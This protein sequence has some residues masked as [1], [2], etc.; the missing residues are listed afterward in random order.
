M[1]I[2]SFNVISL[3]GATTVLATAAFA[4]EMTGAYAGI[5][6]ETTKGGVDNWSELDIDATTG[7]GLFLGYNHDFD[8]FFIGGEVAVSQSKMSNSAG[9]FA[10]DNVTDLKLK[11]GTSLGDYA[12]YGIVSSSSASWSAYGENSGNLSGT[13]FGVGVERQ[14]S[15]RFSL[16]LEYLNRS[17]GD[18]NASYDNDDISTFALR[19]IIRF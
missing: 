10:V 14:L 19:G 12:I 18:S 11:V 1:Q 4:Q 17:M 8:Q 16:G 9:W 13:G 15:D 3:A 5:A 6:Y 7:S 2:N